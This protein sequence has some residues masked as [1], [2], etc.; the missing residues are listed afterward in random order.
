MSARWGF[1]SL[2][3]GRECHNQL[4]ESRN[5][6][7]PE[8]YIYFL[9]LKPLSCQSAEDRETRATLTTT[10]RRTFTSRKRKS[11]QKSLL[12]FS[13]Q[14]PGPLRALLFWDIC[15]LLLKLKGSRW[16]RGHHVLQI[17][18]SFLH[19]TQLNEVVLCHAP[20]PPGAVSAARHT[21]KLCRHLPCA[22]TRSTSPTVF[23]IFYFCNACLFWVSSYL[24]LKKQNKSYFHL[25]VAQSDSVHRFW[26]W[27][28]WRDLFCCIFLLLS[29]VC[30]IPQCFS[31]FGL[32]FI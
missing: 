6:R 2:L 16:N 11:V 17:V 22:A 18:A 23:I 12:T 27:F 31:G 10:K 21:D 19:S 20:S 9:R 1:V 14:G 8:L 13:E 28:E 32:V 25:Q 7:L 30:Y 15:T 26:I 29:V 4:F 5:M 24:F 3:K